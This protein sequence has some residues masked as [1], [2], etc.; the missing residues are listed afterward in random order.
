MRGP[1]QR[2]LPLS[3]YAVI[4]DSRTAALV[5][6]DG[7][8]DW[9][10]YGRFDGPAVFCRLLD[11]DRGGSLDVTPEGVFQSG[12]RYLDRTNVLVT[13]FE[14]G[15]GSLRLTDCMPLGLHTGPVLLR[16][17]EGLSGKVP[18]R[19][20]FR[21]TFDFARA[22]T[23]LEIDDRGCSA[24]SSRFALRLACPTPMTL[25]A[26]CA[27]SRMTLEAGQTHWVI[28]T[29]GDPPFDE[30]A[31]HEA[32]QATIGAWQRW[33]ARGRYPR[34][35]QGVLRRSALVMKLLIHA[36]TGAMV[37]APTTSLPEAPGGTRNWDYRFT[38]L[39]DASW[40]VS[41]LMELGYHSESMAFIS[42][43]ESLGLE[44]GTPAVLYDIDGTVPGHEEN[45]THLC[46][47]R[48]SRPVRVGNAAA[49]QEQ[50]DIFGEV[51]SA[52]YLCS[53]SMPTMRPLRLGLWQLV[54]HLADQALQKWDH[55]DHGMW[56][57]RDKRRRFVS[58]GLLCWTALDRALA[59]ARRDGLT[60]PLDEWKAARDRF[61]DTILSEGVDPEIGFKRA[62]DEVEPDATGL[63]VPRCGLLPADDPRMVRT[64]EVAMERF[65][66][67]GGLLRRYVTD[68]GL[69]G[70]EGAFTACS[71]WLVDCLARQGRLDEACRLFDDVAGYAND[72]GLLSEQ[73]D[74][75]SGTLLGNFPQAF[76][77]LGLVRAAT[78]IAHA[79][80]PSWRL[81]EEER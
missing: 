49:S 64:V 47:Y 71:F 68:D 58:S 35:Y 62:F 43:V 59:I 34:Q 72:V 4:G 16:K 26:G 40:V 67:G 46:G 78:T 50:H 53:S 81:C 52:V 8:I 69:S 48:D 31:A 44:R 42:W 2:D 25:E 73:V 41:A 28:L 63:L 17:L 75:S 39:R 6:T 10:C 36:P 54:S 9:L 79:T 70:T 80:E 7:G 32:M 14:C 18:L 45:L 21:P 15:S 38:W 33:S 74:P 24:K 22:R 3:E 76:S 11:R 56:E 23:D 55:A 66:S 65:S 1:Q 27:K 60:G 20:C 51:I 13:E 29:H 57:V 37:A 61:R 12:R 77:H 5:A 30:E 19:I